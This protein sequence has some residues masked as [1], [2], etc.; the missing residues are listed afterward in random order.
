MPKKLSCAA[1]KRLTAI[2]PAGELFNNLYSDGILPTSELFGV[3]STRVHP[4]LESPNTLKKLQAAIRASDVL[5][6]DITARNPHVMYAVGF[7]HALG[8]PVTMCA[9]FAE[10]VAITDTTG[11]NDPLIHSGSP[12]IL[13]TLL[14]TTLKKLLAAETS[15]RAI[16][17]DTQASL[18]S[19]AR[20]NFL[21]LFGEIL[22][23]QGKL[24]LGRV[25][26]EGKSTFVLEE[27]ELELALVQDLAREARTLGIRLKLL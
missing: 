4:G 16:L 24:R 5:L 21:Q 6:A 27:Q 7:A 2:L 23:D 11:A 3:Q 15:T 9:L 17:T 26:A 12:Q 13:K 1:F 19:D 22:G 8:K 10:D 20:R 25:R 14:T 18:P